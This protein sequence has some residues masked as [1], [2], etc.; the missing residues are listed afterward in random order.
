M[1]EHARITS[2]SVFLFTDKLRLNLVSIQPTPQ[3]NV[4]K[5]NSGLGFNREDLQ[6][7]WLWPIVQ[8]ILKIFPLVLSVIQTIGPMGLFPLSSPVSNESESF[9]VS[10]KIFFIYEI[11]T[12]PSTSWSRIAQSCE[13]H[14]YKRYIKSHQTY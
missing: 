14:S 9:T 1:N 11:L 12:K 13:S 7:I 5:C 3:V 2:L 6:F 4:V 10:I 8:Q